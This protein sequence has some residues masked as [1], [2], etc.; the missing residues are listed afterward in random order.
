DSHCMIVTRKGRLV[1]E[2]YWD[3]WDHTTQ[4][5]VHSVT[6][7]FTS[8]LVGIAQDRD[9][10]SV[11]EPASKW[12]TEW[13]GGASAG[14]TVK[15]LLSNDSGREWT[16]LKDYVEMA[17]GAADKTGFAIGLGQD[18]EPGTHWEYNN[19]AIQTLERVLK[20]ATGDDV[21]AFAQANVF[22]PL[23]M[24]ATMDHDAAGNTLTFGNLKA[25]CDDLARFGY[26]YLRGGK[27]KDQQIVSK[28]YVEEATSVSQPL[29]DAYGYLFWLNND[30]HF[31]R[32]SSP[33]RKEGEGKQIEKLPESTFSALGLGGQ[34]ITVDPEHEIVFARIGGSGD[35]VSAVL[36]GGDP[37]GQDVVSALGNAL[38][39][40]ITK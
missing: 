24:K 32:P 25:S 18:D 4:Q 6:K 17:G 26:L 11:E 3:G 39:D 16:F 5:I 29:N 23:G 40:A 34:M 8:T 2:W 19:S 1:R 27:W 15:N 14:V 10:L 13:A 22:K 9:L 21:A 36:S 12:I 28:A 31:V 7:S 33:A 37:V 38:G 30:G 20:L 35:A